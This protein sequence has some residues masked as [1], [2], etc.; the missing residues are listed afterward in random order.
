[1][2]EKLFFFSVKNEI[3][4]VWQILICYFLTN[5]IFLLHGVSVF[6]I[7]SACF[8][9]SFAC[10]LHLFVFV[11]VSLVFILLLF[12]FSLFVFR[13]FFLAM[14]FAL[15]SSETRSSWVHFWETSASFPFLLWTQYE[16]QWQNLCYSWAWEKMS[17]RGGEIRNITLI[18]ICRK[19]ISPS[20]YLSA[21][22][23]PEN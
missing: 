22:S 14:K 12:G 15:F 9:F 13:V 3:F 7:F 10:F 8:C 17:W 18:S 6:F 4:P 23:A 1:M 2:W 20:L 16:Q 21:A 19:L 11:C 5:L